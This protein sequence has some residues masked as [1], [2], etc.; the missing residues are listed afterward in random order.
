MEPE[1]LSLLVTI[2]EAGTDRQQ[3]DDLAGLLKED[4]LELGVSDVRGASTSPAPDRSKGDPF[5]LGALALVVLPTLLPKLIE[6]LSNWASRSEDRKVKIKTPSGVEVEFT[7]KKLLTSSEILD[8]TKQLD[9][10][11]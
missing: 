8:L 10:K 7:S 4:L 11:V 5:T 1:Q 3:I 2:D 6:C 9:Y